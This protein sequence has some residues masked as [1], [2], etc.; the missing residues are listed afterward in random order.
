MGRVKC[1]RCGMAAERLINDEYYCKPCVPKEEVTPIMPS[2]TPV[3]GEDCTCD[4]LCKDEELKTDG[5]WDRL[6]RW[7]EN[8]GSHHYQ[9]H[10]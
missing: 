6:I 4:D 10:M 2:S 5:F 3:C 8:Y 1:C 9:G 7:F